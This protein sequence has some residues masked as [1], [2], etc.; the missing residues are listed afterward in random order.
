MLIAEVALG[1]VA[2]L[3]L[4]G[5]LSRWAAPRPP[6]PQDATEWLRAPSSS[7]PRKDRAGVK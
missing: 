6:L 1:V 4:F 3:W 2:G 5:A 7:T